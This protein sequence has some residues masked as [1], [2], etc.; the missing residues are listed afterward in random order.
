MILNCLSTMS[1]GGKLYP[2][3]FSKFV[4]CNSTYITVKSSLFSTGRHLVAKQL[5]RT[6]QH[7]VL[8]LSSLH[9][10][11]TSLLLQVSFPSAVHYY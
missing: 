3:K 11:I 4:L 5:K 10:H 1:S 9:R 2:I 8:E 7:F 6:L